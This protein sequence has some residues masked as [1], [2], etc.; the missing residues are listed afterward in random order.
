M[1]SRIQGRR[2]SSSG[3][4]VAD[5]RQAAPSFWSDKAA[6]ARQKLPTS[7]R[8]SFPVPS[9]PGRDFADV[10]ANQ[11]PYGTYKS[12]K[13]NFLIKYIGFG[14]RSRES[15]G[16]K[17]YRTCQMIPVAS[18]H[19]AETA[20]RIQRAADTRDSGSSVPPHHHPTH[21]VSQHHP[22][23]TSY[24]GRSVAPVAAG[25]PPSAMILHLPLDLGCEADLP[26]RPKI[27]GSIP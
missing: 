9:R 24:S 4:F 7:D 12:I 11:L 19:E 25:R 21:P 8:N 15:C 10:R 2:P 14:P 17:G 18:V 27:L 13:N 16:R 22:I 3:S 5:A 23:P 6:L 20:H 1:N 26:G